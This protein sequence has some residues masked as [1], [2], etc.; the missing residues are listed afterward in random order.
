MVDL[1]EGNHL[2]QN[3]RIYL[4][5]TKQYFKLTSLCFSFFLKMQ[6]AYFSTS[7]LIYS[8]LQ[9]IRDPKSFSEFCNSYSVSLL[10]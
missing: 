2:R 4:E 10:I 1:S 8:S 9:L 7:L 5:A 3:K 6:N